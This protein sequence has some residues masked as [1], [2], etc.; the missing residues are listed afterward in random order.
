PHYREVLLEQQRR[1]TLA[2][3]FRVAEK[4]F[5]LQKKT[6]RQI[7]VLQPWESDESVHSTFLNK[8][9]SNITRAIEAPETEI[10]SSIFRH[11]MELLNNNMP[12][13]KLPQEV[14]DAVLSWDK[15]E[16]T[17]REALKI[18]SMKEELRKVRETGDKTAVTEM[19]RELA[20]QIQK[21]VS[22]YPYKKKGA[23][24]PSYNIETQNINCAAASNLAGTLLSELGIN[25]VVG[26]FSDHS[27]LFLIHPTGEI[28]YADMLLEP[29]MNFTL[30]NEMIKESNK[31]KTPF[32]SEDI[33]TYSS[34]Q[35]QSILKFGIDND[36]YEGYFDPNDDFSF[37]NF[38]GVLKPEHGHIAQ[39][40]TT[41]GK[42]FIA[43]DLFPAATDSFQ[44][45]ISS[46]L[47]TSQ[48]RINLAVALYLSGRNA[49]A[50]KEYKNAI[51]LNRNEIKAYI[52]LGRVLRATDRK[53]DA[54]ATYKKVI[55]LSDPEK[56][57]EW[58]EEAKSKIDE[59]QSS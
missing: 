1:E 19:E 28:V 5:D 33:A 24:M 45:V 26:E 43:N 39:M 35:R 6:L 16:E 23:N 4:S 46:G 44:R 36:T 22:N 8:T 40:Y 50:I 38:E 56:D 18:D 13:D 54:Q 58:I 3:Y 20:N 27:V 10:Y 49:E 59:L 57:S 14:K 37:R 51:L 29:E 9:Q 47:D 25:Y 48:S 15:G 31:N 2:R 17:L 12:F 53:E 21:T 34:D 55:E 7:E 30:T 32:T 42:L 11:G 52:G 41:L